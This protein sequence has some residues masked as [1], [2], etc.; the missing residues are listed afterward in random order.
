MTHAQDRR[1]AAA[2]AVG[3]VSL[4]VGLLLACVLGKEVG[5]PLQSC[6]RSQPASLQLL[7]LNYYYCYYYA[8]ANN[9][10]G[11]SKSNSGRRS[12]VVSHAR[13]FVHS[14]VR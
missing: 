9:M 1:A 13:S 4:R 5:E 11:S 2:A 6:F 14:F 3:K 8:V 10:R 7:G 12:I